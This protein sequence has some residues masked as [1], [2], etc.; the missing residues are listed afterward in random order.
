MG[1][2]PYS[3]FRGL[4][5]LQDISLWKCAPAGRSDRE[6]PSGH[7][8]HLPRHPRS[9]PPLLDTVNTEKGQGRGPF[10]H[11]KQGGITTQLG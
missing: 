9:N 10:L 4:G 2:K 6:D 5:H 11:P 3:C 8:G 1:L 7:Q